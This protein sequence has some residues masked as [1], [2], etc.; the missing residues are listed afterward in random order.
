MGNR[1]DFDMGKKIFLVFVIV[2]YFTIL[3]INLF[4]KIDMNY[5]LILGK[6]FY[7]YR[8]YNI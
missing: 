8:F 1:K 2:L 4:D 7:I 3:K 6:E 5:K